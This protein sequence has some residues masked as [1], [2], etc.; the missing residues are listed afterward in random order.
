MS[1]DNDLNKLKKN[2]KQKSIFI[3]Q[4]KPLVSRLCE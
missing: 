1:N 2:I 4:D 3:Q